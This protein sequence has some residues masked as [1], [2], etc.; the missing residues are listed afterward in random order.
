MIHAY[1]ACYGD[2]TYDLR[3]CLRP[4]HWHTITGRSYQ[5][6]TIIMPKQS[7]SSSSKELTES[8][9]CEQNIQTEMKIKKKK[10]MNPVKV[11]WAAGACVKIQ[12]VCRVYTNALLMFYS[13]STASLCVCCVRMCLC[14]LV[15]FFS[16]LS[17]VGSVREEWRHGLNRRQRRQHRWWQADSWTHDQIICVSLS[18]FILLL[19]L[20]STKTGRKFPT[21]WR[22][23]DN[24]Y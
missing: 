19:K 1:L 22:Y 10:H 18:R 3:G 13:T 4:Y 7:M 14:T 23:C 8:S 20:R 24:K 5:T 9:T 15:V 16:L 2:S 11:K 12:Y 17:A 6:C 21:T